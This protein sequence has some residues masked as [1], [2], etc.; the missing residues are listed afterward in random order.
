[1]IRI[2]SLSALDACLDERGG[3]EDGR[4]AGIDRSAGGAVSL[5]LEVPTAVNDRISLL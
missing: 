5:R 2:S 3:F 4:L 1:M